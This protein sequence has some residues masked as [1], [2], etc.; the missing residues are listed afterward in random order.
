MTEAAIVATLSSASDI[1]E[2]SSLP[3]AVKWLE[4]R[5]DMSDDIDADSLRSRFSGGLIYTLR[6]IGESGRFVGSEETRRRRLLNASKTY[7]IID[8]EGDRDLVPELL[9]EIPANRR[10]I[11]WSGPAVDCPTLT[12]RLNS[13][14]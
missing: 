9:S 6:S 8:L 2:L 12:Q 5:A 11:S 13:F 14:S 3:E 10:M 4:V 1:D 7:D